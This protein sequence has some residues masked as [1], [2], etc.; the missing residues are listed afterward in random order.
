MENNKVKAPRFGRTEKMGT[1]TFVICAIALA[2]VVVVNLLVGLL[3]SSLT[4]FDTSATGLFTISDGTQKFIS[5]L[6]EDVTINWIC[7]NGSTE[8]RLETFFEK[9]VSLSSHL[10]LRILDPIK[11]PT[12]LDKY[13]SD[14][15]SQPSNYSLVIESARRYTVI[16]ANELFY[17]YNSLLDE[18]YGLGTVPYSVYKYYNSYFKLAENNG[19]PTEQ[20]FYGDDTVTKGIEYV[21]LD[22]IPHI[23]I[24]E[25]HGEQSFSATMLD[26]ISQNNVTYETLSLSDSIPSDAGCIVI[27]NP[28]FDLSDSETALLRDYLSGG[29]NLLLITSPDRTSFKNLMSLMEN[30]GLS[31][32]DGTVCE[33]SLSHY[34]DSPHDLKPNID[35]SHEISSLISK[36]SVLMPNS[37]GIKISDSTNGATVTSLFTTSSSAYM[38]LDDTKGETGEITVAAALSKPAGDADTR[39][40]WFSSAEAFTD[41][42]AAASSYGNYYYLFYSLYWMNETYE[43][44][45]ATVKGPSLSEPLLDQLTQTS[46]IGWGLVF[47]V[48]IP[49]AILAVGIAIWVKRKKR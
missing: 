35:T 21:T 14:S 13:I 49:G 17:Y 8:Q 42:I 48:V 27:F 16:D 39:I 20:F 44:S 38:Q 37:H 36:Y 29:G 7:Q 10:R 28:K 34:K 45:L 4:T 18:S 19:Y 46:V 2:V 33:G 26:F 9:Y 30:Y 40:V 11:N 43:S 31:P 47:T 12:A 25:N 41:D 6:D 23:Y 1:Y 3:P 24:S 5:S 22:K 32:L 15:D